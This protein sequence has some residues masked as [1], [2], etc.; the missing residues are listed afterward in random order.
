MGCVRSKPSLASPDFL[1]H[2]AADHL[3]ESLDDG[4]IVGLIVRQLKVKDT[5]RRTSDQSLELC[6]AER[7]QV[8][9]SRLFLHLLRHAYEFV[10]ALFVKPNKEANRPIRLWTDAFVRVRSDGL[11]KAT[12]QVI[13]RA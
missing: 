1:Q 2:A 5:G 11:A 6:F 8:L 12:G 7:W 10:Q 4:T 13:A 3:G 9:V